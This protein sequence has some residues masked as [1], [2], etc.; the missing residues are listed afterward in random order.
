MRASPS[1]WRADPP[2]TPTSHTAAGTHMAKVP[3]DPEQ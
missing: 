2:A 1:R 3:Q